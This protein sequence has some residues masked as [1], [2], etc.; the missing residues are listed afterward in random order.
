MPEAII[1]L[2]ANLGQP[3]EALFSIYIQSS[4]FRL[5]IAGSKSI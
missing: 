3:V 4:S 1:A 2:G 5:H